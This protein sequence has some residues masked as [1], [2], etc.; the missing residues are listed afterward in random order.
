MA[1]DNPG[2]TGVSAVNSAG[3]GSGV[4]CGFGC[5]CGFGT[6]TGAAVAAADAA[7]PRAC[8][9]TACVAAFVPMPCFMRSLWLSNTCH[10]SYTFVSSAIERVC[11]SKVWMA[12]KSLLESISV[13]CLSTLPTFACAARPAMSKSTNCVKSYMHMFD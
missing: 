10:A 7:P 2:A 6:V 8:G 9:P 12:G 1:T 11:S 3:S 5:G 13:S 4:G